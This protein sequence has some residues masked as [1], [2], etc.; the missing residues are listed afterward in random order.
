MDDCTG[1][2]FDFIRTGMRGHTYGKLTR[3][4]TKTGPSV[5]GN[6]PTPSLCI[7]KHAS[8][9]TKLEKVLFNEQENHSF[10]G[11]IIEMMINPEVLCTKIMTHPQVSWQ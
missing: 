2:H 4:Q 9:V 10:P 8:K 5:D 6:R 3:S 11:R 1:D 7:I